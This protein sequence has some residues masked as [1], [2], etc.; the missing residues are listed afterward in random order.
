MLQ[1]TINPHC[2]HP[3]SLV[4]TVLTVSCGDPLKLPQL[5]EQNR[6]LGAR[7]EVAGEPE[8]A[9]PAPD[10]SATVRWLVADPEEPRPVSWA[11]SVCEAEAVA[12]G[13]PVC[14][15]PPF[16][17]AESGAPVLQEPRFEFTLPSAAE[18]Q[19][20]P[21]IALLGVICA[22]GTAE[23]GASWSETDCV[24]A[25]AQKTYVNLDILVAREGES[26]HNPSVADLPIQ[27]D[28]QAWPAADPTLLEQTD[29]QN[30]PGDV[31][32][33]APGSGE[34]LLRFEPADRDREPLEVDHPLDPPRET[35][36]LSHYATAGQLDRPYSA[37]DPEDR[38]S[39]IIVPWEAPSTATAEGRLVRFYLVARDLRGGADW[40]VRALCL[41]P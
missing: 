35:L 7:V 25:Q 6:V 39:P 12:R 41:Q 9:S 15:N 16:A 14:R 2:L 5:I 40:T 17:A 8:R 37:I 13:T 1:T 18:L 38:I 34:H 33:V 20:A 30:L 32:H 3:A 29:C 19:D 10:E 21:R 11:F 26:N 27:L 28:G 22:D 36:I 4:A 31:P 23:L 24:G